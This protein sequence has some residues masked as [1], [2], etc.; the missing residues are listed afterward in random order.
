[1]GGINTGKL[2]VCGFLAG[3]V[4]NCGQ[5]VVHLFLLAERSAALTEGMG[6]PEPTGGQIGIYW[7]I[8]FAVGFAMIFVYAGFRP[9][10]GAGP[11]TAVLAAATTY[12][13]AELIPSLFFIASGIFGFGEYLPFFISTL[14]ILMVAG[15]VGAWPYSEDRGA[16]TG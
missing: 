7:L 15:V 11:G 2:L 4:I 13:L 12:V 10:F 9:R 8:S 14:V 16:A 3:I 5:T 6:L 1:M